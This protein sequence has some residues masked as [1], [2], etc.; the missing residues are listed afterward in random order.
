MGKDPEEPV[1]WD[2]LNYLIAYGSL[3]IATVSKT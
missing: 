1:D 3:I 2:S